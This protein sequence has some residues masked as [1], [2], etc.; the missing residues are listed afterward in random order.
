MVEKGLIEEAQ[1]LH[2]YKALTALNTVGYKELFDYFEGKYDKS[3]AI[4]RIQSNTRTYM[5]KQLTWFKKDNSIHWFESANIKEIIKYID[6][7]R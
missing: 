7:L 2:P 5:R 3:E 6:Q 4:R 1:K